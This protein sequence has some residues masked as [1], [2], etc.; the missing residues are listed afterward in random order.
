MD[1]DLLTDLIG[2]IVNIDVRA[3]RSGWGRRRHGSGCSIDFPTVLA[4]PISILTE[5]M[6][7]ARVGSTRAEPVTSVRLTEFPRE[8]VT[9]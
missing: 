4:R 9:P 1:D 7:G 8:E 5:P 6:I 3:A 2:A